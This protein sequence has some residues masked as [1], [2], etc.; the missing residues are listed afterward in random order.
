[1]GCQWKYLE[2]TGLKEKKG[3][4]LHCHGEV[5]SQWWGIVSLH[6]FLGVLHTLSYL[7]SKYSLTQASKSVPMNNRHGTIDNVVSK[8][9]NKN[10]SS[11]F[12]RRKRNKDTMVIYL[13]SSSNE[14]MIFN[15][16]AQWFLALHWDFFFHHDV[17]SN[18]R[19]EE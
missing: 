9:E 7:L 13:P 14:N 12:L 5:N 8:R 17:A 4:V 16:V 15:H 3:S 2:I 6:F 18:I 11:T 1:M 19:V 10:V